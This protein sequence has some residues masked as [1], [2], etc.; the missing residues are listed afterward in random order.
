MELTRLDAR[1]RIR[2]II[3]SELACVPQEALYAHGGNLTSN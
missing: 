1:C 3:P 2:G